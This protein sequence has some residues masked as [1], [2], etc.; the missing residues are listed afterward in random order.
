MPPAHVSDLHHVMQHEARTNGVLMNGT[1][2]DRKLP[3]CIP[4][5]TRTCSFYDNLIILKPRPTK[6]A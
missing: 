5:I 3:T 4:D 2:E 6:T 1:L